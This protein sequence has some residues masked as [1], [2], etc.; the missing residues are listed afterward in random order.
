M[1][2]P[3]VAIKVKHYLLIVCQVRVEASSAVLLCSCFF[4]LPMSALLFRRIFFLCTNLCHPNT[5]SNP[6][7]GG[8]IKVSL[9]SLFYFFFTCRFTPPRVSSVHHISSPQYYVIAS[10]SHPVHHS[11][12]PGVFQC[13]LELFVDI[14][15]I[16]L[17]FL[18]LFLFL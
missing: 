5:W 1:C 4:S 12:F 10:P 13:R 15:F 7:S 18:F 8:M 14:F 9:C 11:L 17:L 3:P 6:A 2:S 16:F